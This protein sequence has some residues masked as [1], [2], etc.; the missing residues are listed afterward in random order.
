VPITPFQL[1]KYKEDKTG[2]SLDKII[3]F[4]TK[5]VLAIGILEGI[6]ILAL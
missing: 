2:F 4:L 3:W 1:L 6:I 5:Q